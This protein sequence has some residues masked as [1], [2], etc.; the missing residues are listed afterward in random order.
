MSPDTLTVQGRKAIET[1]EIIIGSPRLLELLGTTGRTAFAE[2]APDK[3]AKIISSRKESHFVVLVSGD[4]GFYS[5]SGS[6]AEFLR[7]CNVEYIPGISSFSYFFAK[8]KRDYQTCAFV[9]LHGRDANIAEA[10]RRSRLTFVLT[11]GNISETAERLMEYGFGELTAY[12]GEN[13]GAWNEQ[14]VITRLSQVSQLAIGNLAVLL[15]ENQN[16][17][18]RI[19]FGIPDGEFVRRELPMTKAEVRAIAM[20]KLAVQ[21]QD[22][23]WDVG[24]GTGSVTVELALAAYSGKVF[25]FD[26]NPDALSLT[27]L[28]CRKFGIS[29]VI[30]IQGEAPA[31]FE[32]IQKPDAV[33][34]GGSG[35]YLP[36]IITSAIQSRLVI[37]AV[38]IETA[39][40]ACETLKSLGKTYSAARI[41][42][43]R[44]SR[45]LKAEN[46][47]TVIW[48][49]S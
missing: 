1:A 37:T 36:Q 22:V 43:E 15:I 25:A 5:A 23:C 2:Y 44:G 9:S 6:I 12:I 21:P 28:N 39:Y 27:E 16:A 11:G 14:I 24:C 4:V 8:I 26:K 40:T 30:P 20:S 29:N 49:E 19:R 45:I 35:G 32:A 13:L 33:F 34:I 17:E 48:T 31:A 46:S 38:T 3:A 47:V 18:S 42:I 41:S 7:D 10:V